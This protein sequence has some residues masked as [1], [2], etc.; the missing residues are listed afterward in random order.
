MRQFPLDRAD[1]RRFVCHSYSN[2]VYL[3]LTMTCCFLVQPF[4]ASTSARHLIMNEKETEQV[5]QSASDC[6]DSECSLEEV[7]DLINVLKET[8]SELEARLEKIM[9]MIAHL[10]H[11]NEKEERKTDEVRRFVQDMLR[12]FSTDVSQNLVEETNYFFYIS[13][14][15][16]FLHR[17]LPTFL[18]ALLAKLV[19]GQRLLT[20][21]FP[22]RSGQTP[23]RRSKFGC[24]RHLIIAHSRRT[25]CD[26]QLQ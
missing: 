24:L 10:Q 13:S 1:T 15:L 5:L 21:L 18:R 12:V 4:V 14:L 22:P 23:I 17:N 7:S 11:I 3:S 9:N 25:V 16:N 20:M 2:I 26:E 8:E 6:V 19:M